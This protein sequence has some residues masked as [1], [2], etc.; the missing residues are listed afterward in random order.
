M[1]AEER[2]LLKLSEEAAEVIKEAAK[3]LRFGTEIKN[4]ITNTTNR[5]RL[6]EEVKDLI[7]TLQKL[8]LNYS[9]SKEQFNARNDKYY[10]WEKFSENC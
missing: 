5:E 8:E 3:C 1:S 4:P 6:Q 10:K 7:F 9:L 2:L